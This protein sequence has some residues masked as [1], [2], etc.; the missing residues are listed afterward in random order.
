MIN[1]P[2]C[3]KKNLSDSA[4]CEYCGARFQG[5]E[6]IEQKSE[7]VNKQMEKMPT[8]SIDDWIVWASRSG[9]S[10]LFVRKVRSIFETE[11]AM[12]P[13]NLAIEVSFAQ[14]TEEVPASGITPNIIKDFIYM[15]PTLWYGGIIILGYIFS[16]SCILSYILFEMKPEKITLPGSTHFTFL[17]FF[18]SGCL[19]I[20]LL[21]LDRSCY[22]KRYR[23]RL[24]GTM[25]IIIIFVGLFHPIMIFIASQIF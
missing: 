20:H 1:C 19:G 8:S 11:S 3:G 12:L 24:H 25:I 2:R 5:K 7:E 16:I 6:R 18:L 13:T 21:L 4:Y 10:E 14:A 9:Y 23:T 15:H 22:K 17:L